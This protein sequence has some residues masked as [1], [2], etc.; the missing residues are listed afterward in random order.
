MPFVSFIYKIGDD[1][2]TYYGKWNFTYISDDHEG[3]DTE[4]MSLLEYAYKLKNVFRVAIIGFSAHKYFDYASEKEISL[5]DFYCE[6]EK[7]YYIN[8]N[9]I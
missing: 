8:G 2:K 1:P 7:T 6:E 4:I 5:F 9:K 3:L